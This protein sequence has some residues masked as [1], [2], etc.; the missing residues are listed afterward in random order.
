MTENNTFYDNIKYL[1]PGHYF[2][3]IISKKLSNPIKLIE[4]LL[5][6]NNQLK[7]SVINTNQKIMKY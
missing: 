3:F 6:N 1:S 7:R 4:N 2:E 5:V